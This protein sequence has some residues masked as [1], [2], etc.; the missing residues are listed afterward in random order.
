[1]EKAHVTIPQTVPL[2]LFGVQVKVLFRLLIY[3]CGILG[4]FVYVSSLIMGANRNHFENK[5]DPRSK[6]V[7][8]TEKVKNAN[9]QNRPT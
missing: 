7:V 9:P 8:E 2:T 5:K 4:R 6:H 1:M 3:I